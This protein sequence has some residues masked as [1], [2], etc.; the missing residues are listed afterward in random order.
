MIVVGF[1]A[2]WWIARSENIGLREERKRL[3][4]SDAETR[5]FL[6]EKPASIVQDGEGRWIVT[7]KP[8]A[9]K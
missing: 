8:K 3:M 6:A 9:E 7:M 5:R 4:E 1:G 2:G